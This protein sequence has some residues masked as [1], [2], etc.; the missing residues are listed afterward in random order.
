MYVNDNNVTYFDAFGVEN[1]PKDIKRI[2]RNINI[3]TN[4][5]I[6]QAYESIMYGYCC[7]GFIDF[8]LKSKRLLDYA[9][10]FSPKIMKR[11]IK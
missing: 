10:L 11:M 9:S 1:V 6:I 3:I 5:Y 7:I 4:I 2:I 8:I